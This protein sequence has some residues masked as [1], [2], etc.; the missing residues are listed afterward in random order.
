[1]VNMSH[2]AGGKREVLRAGA[3][4]C[5]TCCIE[6]IEI[7]FDFEFDGIILDNV[8]AL[9][10]P[11]CQEEIFTPEQFEAIQKRLHGFVPP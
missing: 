9:K 1:M 3:L 2:D 7:E 10:C 6:Y 5:P 8:K 4:I 11:V